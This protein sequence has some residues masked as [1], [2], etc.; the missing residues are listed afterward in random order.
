MRR[1][2]GLPVC[3]LLL[4]AGGCYQPRPLDARGVLE[5]VADEQRAETIASAP[6]LPPAPGP[7]VAIS[8][9][10]S[11]SIGA[12]SPAGESGAPVAARGAVQNPG[13]REPPDDFEELTEDQA[14]ARALRFNPGLRARRHQLGIAEGQ[15]TAATALSN[16]TVELEWL[17]L[18]SPADHGFSAKLAWAPPQPGIYAA[19]RGAAQAQAKAVKSEIA[20]SEWELL[21]AVR[22]A[23]ADL[24]A[25]T[26]QR[27]LVDASLIKR[28]RIHELVQQRVRGGASTSIDLSLAQLSVADG[29]RQREDLSSQ[30][31]QGAR[32]LAEL[33]GCS[34]PVWAR[35]V[36]PE[37]KA[38]LPA[39]GA[40][41]DAAL[42]SRPA[43]TAEQLRFLQREEEIRLES[44]RR[45]PWF[46][47]TT[48]PRYRHDSG[49]RHPDDFQVGVRFTV[50]IFDQNAGPIRM[51]EAAR[52]A[53]REQ[54]RQQGES[55]RREIA[56]GL[57]EVAQRRRSL[58]RYQRAVLP[59][60]DA[61]EKLLIAAAQG[62]QID[63]VTV[64]RA[65]DAILRSRSEFIAVRLAH[66]RAWLRLDSAT[67]RHLA[68]AEAD[69]GPGDPG[70]GTSPSVGPSANPDAP[71]RAPR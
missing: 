22:A 55:I 52:D 66:H 18:E 38:P 45:W 49:S 16:P 5:E 26:E 51:A 70:R 1:R 43:L 24:V 34:R 44:A 3:A 46:E 64:L 67:G 8:G 33:L 4:G 48:A 37:E 21:T 56:A 9:R 54:F 58:E 41:V 17:R 27:Q 50:P 23:H 32:E 61:H 65:E 53:Q 71:P 25:I 60:L 28:R 59:G 10:P 68:E 31:L 13:V 7:A 20:E 40:L 62:G 30:A 19:K 2:H 57:A 11:V 12:A 29:E 6:S 63:V 15:I 35:G 36:V 14:V 47:L 42:T 39:Y 69:A